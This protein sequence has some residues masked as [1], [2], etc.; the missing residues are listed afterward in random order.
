[1]RW[2]WSGNQQISNGW[3]A[4]VTQSGTQITAVNAAWNGAIA[5]GASASFGFQAAYSGVNTSPTQFSV[6][7]LACAS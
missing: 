6:N 5:S 1:V 4:T 3:N 2:T 7:G